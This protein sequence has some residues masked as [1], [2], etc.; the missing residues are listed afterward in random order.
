MEQ[1][2]ETAVKTNSSLMKKTKQQLVDI[3]FRKDS[4]EKDLNNKVNNLQKELDNKCREF[5]IIN[6]DYKNK[7]KTIKNLKIELDKTYQLNNRLTNKHDKLDKDY[8]DICDEYADYVA[9]TNIKLSR[10]KK[11]VV[12]MFIMLIINLS[13]FLM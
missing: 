6:E 11:I 9:F 10:Y 2:K 4:I 5:N 3:I 8:Q 1:N 12:I 13:L 7:N